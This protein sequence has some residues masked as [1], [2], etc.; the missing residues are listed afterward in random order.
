MKRVRNFQLAL[1][2]AIE[3]LTGLFFLGYHRDAQAASPLKDI[4][5]THVDLEPGEATETGGTHS[6]MIELR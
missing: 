4:T 1:L 3:V 5:I 6:S 2:V